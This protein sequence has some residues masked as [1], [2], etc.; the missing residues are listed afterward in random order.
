MK[1]FPRILLAVLSVLLAV[2]L[3]ITAVFSG[4]VSAV[5]AHFS[6]E[7]VYNFMNS[8]DYA[9][10]ELP[11]GNGGS[12]PMTDLVNEQIKPFGIVLTEND[13]NVLIRSFHIDTILASFMQDLRTYFLDDG[14]VP[15]LDPR[16][17]AEM[18]L[19]GLDERLYAFLSMMGDPTAILSDALNN[20]LSTT[21]LS[22][23]LSSSEPVRELLSAGTLAFV[24]SV[25]GTLFLLILVTRRLRLV[26]TAVLTGCSCAAAGTV[27]LFAETILAP[28]MAGLITSSGLP[29]AVLNPVYLPFMET[30]RRTGTFMALGGLAAA[31]IFGVF[32]VFASMIRRE[33]E[34]AKKAA[35][36][37]SGADF[38]AALYG[39]MPPS[40]EGA[41][42]ADNHSANNNNS[43]E[44]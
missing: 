4:A 24:I 25:S 19:S 16:E 23:S 9:A 2:L 32:G 44:Y 26:P 30:V 1:T 35:E 39:S 31:I 15:A 34:A 20:L 8:L 6:P 29:A 36:Q 11:D 22:A 37:R 17:T 21:D 7:Y 43:P 40:G 18:L 27:L 28:F 12:A 5:R 13:L 33:K 38:Y 41:A 42:P 10:L 3:T 14:P